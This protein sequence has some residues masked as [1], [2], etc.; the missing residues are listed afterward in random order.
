M[1]LRV[2]VVPGAH[3]HVSVAADGG[4]Q[5]GVGCGPGLLVGQHETW[6][7]ASWPSPGTGLTRCGVRMEDT[8]RSDPHQHLGPGVPQPMAKGDAVI[9]GVEDEERHLGVIGQQVDQAPNLFDGGSSSVHGWADAQRV[10]WRGPAVRRP[11]QLADPLIGP[12]GHDGL[13]GRVLGGRVVESPLGAALGVASVPARGIDS[14]HQRP[15]LWA[16]LNQ[17][18][19]EPALG[20]VTVGQ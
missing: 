5:L 1:Q 10:Q 19:T 13:S 7:V 2:Q 16:V 14:E 3:L 15:R 17:Q 6:S 12:P 4:N 20:H 18:F 8:G 11:V 9:P